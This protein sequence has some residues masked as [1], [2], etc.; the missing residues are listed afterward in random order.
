MLQSKGRKTVFF[1]YIA[2][3]MYLWLTGKFNCSTMGTYVTP[4]KQWQDWYQPSKEVAFNENSEE[5]TAQ[6]HSGS[7]LYT[8]KKDPV[9]G[10]YMVAARDIQPGEVVFTDQP[11][12]IGK[13][14][15][16]FP[17]NYAIIKVGFMCYYG[18]ADKRLLYRPP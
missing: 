3:S 5:P 2:C 13:S 7:V 15:C 4:A 14:N 1:L 17:S 9:V 10:R 18:H 6:D 11:A 8:I 12:V 16:Q